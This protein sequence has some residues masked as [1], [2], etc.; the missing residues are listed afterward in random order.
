MPG[1]R[2]DDLRIKTLEFIFEILLEQSTGVVLK[3]GINTVIVP[4]SHHRRLP[5]PHTNTQVK[6]AVTAPQR[7]PRVIHVIWRLSL[8]HTHPLRYALPLSQTT[9][10]TGDLSRL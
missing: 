5:P 10:S 7:S 4:V 1:A 9:Q 2:R 3:T 6:D 8:F